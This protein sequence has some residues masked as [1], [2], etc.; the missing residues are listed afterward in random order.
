VRTLSERLDAATDRIEARLDRT[1]DCWLWP[2]GTN[3]KG[4]GVL[5]VKT[6]VDRGQVMLYVHRVMFERYVRPLVGDEEVDH[7]CFVRNCGNP[8]HLEAVTHAENVR[9]TAARIT[10]CPRNHLYTPENTAIR[11]GKRRCR[12]CERDRAYEQRGIGSP[13]RG[14]YRQEVTP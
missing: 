1:G 6:G 7:S 9:R 11:S 4:Y 5:A 10:A 12:T 13:R 2:G 8:A 14:P 3:G